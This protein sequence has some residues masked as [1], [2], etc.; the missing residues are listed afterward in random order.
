MKLQKI[1]EEPGNYL[2][3]FHDIDPW[4]S[5]HK[6]ILCLRSDSMVNI[7]SEENQAEIVLVNLEDGKVKTI[8]QT[9]CWNFPQGGRQAWIRSKDD[10]KIIY[11]TRIGDEFVAKIVDKEGS[12]FLTCDKAT[13]CVSPCYK[14]SYGLNYERLYRLGGYGYAGVVD[15]T[16]GINAPSNDGIWK[17]DLTTGKSSLI[18]S[19]QDITKI[20]GNTT[21]LQETEHYVTHILASPNGKKISFLHRYWLPDGGIQT[22]LI[23]CGS[24]GKNGEVWDEGFLSHF[25]WVDDDTIIMWGKPASKAQ[26]LR[27][28]SFLKSIPLLSP[29]IQGLKPLIKKILG[30]KIIPSGYYKL[31]SSDKKFLSEKF[32]EVLPLSDGHPS[33]CP[34]K[35]NLLLTD[36]YPDENMERELMILNTDDQKLHKITKLKESTQKGS[37]K[38]FISIEKYIDSDMLKKFSMKHFIH[39]RSGVHCDFHPRWRRDGK[40]ICIDSNHEDFRSIYIYQVPKELLNE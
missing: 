23:I 9:M 13:N 6:E 12:E 21:V 11:N 10:D 19:L 34:E 31:V 2:V 39:S 4:S 25:D 35:R 16:K 5:N 22:R 38:N 17:I 20:E 14:Y 30:K 29:I 3:G 33:F 36:T 32:S 28:S 26:A 8:D 18:L 37:D 40:Y 27:S 1:T 24:D 15:K 7:P